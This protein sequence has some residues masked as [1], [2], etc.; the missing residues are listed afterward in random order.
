MAEDIV[1]A[2]PAARLER[3][4]SAVHLSNVEQPDRFNAALRAFPLRSA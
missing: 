2:I 3:I 4:P 1:R